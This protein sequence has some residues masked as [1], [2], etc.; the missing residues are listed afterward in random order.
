MCTLQKQHDYF[1]EHFKELLTKYD[2]K[3]LVISENLTIDAFEDKR[4]AYRFGCNTFGLGHFMLKQCTKDALKPI[5][6][7]PIISYV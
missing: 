2:G 6:I 1:V 7:N 5:T 3:H 4:T